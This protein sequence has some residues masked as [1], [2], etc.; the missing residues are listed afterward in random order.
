MLPPNELGGPSLWFRTAT[1]VTGFPQDGSRTRTFSARAAPT[2]VTRISE[3]GSPLEYSK[4][5]L[6]FSAWS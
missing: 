2:V 5:Q 3:S 4:G 1:T 6:P